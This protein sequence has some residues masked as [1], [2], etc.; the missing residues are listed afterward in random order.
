MHINIIQKNSREDLE[1]EINKIMRDL[2][3]HPARDRN[4]TI[5]KDIKFTCNEDSFS[6]MIIF[7]QAIL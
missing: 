7:D 1:D 6:A 4:H 3:S 5:V 2:Y